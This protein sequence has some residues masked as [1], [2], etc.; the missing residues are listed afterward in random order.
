MTIAIG[1][2][3]LPKAKIQEPAGEV[4]GSYCTIAPFAA[5][6]RTAS[7]SEARSA[8]SALLWNYQRDYFN[9]DH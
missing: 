2:F 3:A 6:Q 5:I 4:S 8:F 7:L 9:R 1:H